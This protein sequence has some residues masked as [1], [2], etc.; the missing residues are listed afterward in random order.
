M[1]FAIIKLKTYYEDEFFI[2]C[3]IQS[4]SDLFNI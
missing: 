1:I 2:N 4:L 3:N